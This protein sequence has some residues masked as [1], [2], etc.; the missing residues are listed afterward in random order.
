MESFI[1]TRGVDVFPIR[2]RLI[3]DESSRTSSSCTRQVGAATATSETTKTTARSRGIPGLTLRLGPSWNV[4]A[5]SST[6]R[7][8]K[9]YKSRLIC[10]LTLREWTRG[11]S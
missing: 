9:A 2:V 8:R 11:E 1:T 10:L 3:P 6:A 4:E 5:F 7:A